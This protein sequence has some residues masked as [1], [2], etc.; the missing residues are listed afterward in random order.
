MAACGA[1]GNVVEEKEDEQEQTFA[2]ALG[3]AQEMTMIY[4]SN[5]KNS[6]AFYSKNFGM[7][8]RY[9]YTVQ[10]KSATT[11]KDMS[12]TVALL[13]CP[14]D[15]TKLPNQPIEGAILLNQIT[16]DDEY[17]LNEDTTQDRQFGGL[18]FTCGDLVEECKTLET[19]GVTFLKKPN[20][21]SGPMGG[22]GAKITDPDGTPLLLF[23]R[24]FY[25]LPALTRKWNLQQLIF[26]TTD[27]KKAVDLYTLL[28]MGPTFKGG[29]D[30]FKMTMLRNERFLAPWRALGK[31]LP[32][33]FS[34]IPNDKKSTLNSYHNTLEII[35]NN[36]CKK[37]KSTKYCPKLCFMAN[38]LNALIAGLKKKKFTIMQQFANMIMVADFDGGV[39]C[40][41]KRNPR[42]VFA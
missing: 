14:Q 18:V 28:G 21:K 10:L 2:E 20:D 30:S 15:P 40:F 37:V 8:K 3:L 16:G 41:V 33:K 25:G 1:K 27:L 39:L 34:D 32:I 9:E 24:A 4:V 29:T 38:D 22:K 35:C 7:T 17:K 36:G 6:I 13:D 12:S 5:V 23:A 19:N 31:D 42:I 26:R 11:G